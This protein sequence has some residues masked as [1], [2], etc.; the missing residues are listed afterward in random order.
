M[1]V[2][3]LYI[4]ITSERAKYHC[5]SVSYFFLHAKVKEKITF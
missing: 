1:I 3:M 4:E 2:W 5:T